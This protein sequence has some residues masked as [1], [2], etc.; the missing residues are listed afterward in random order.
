MPLDLS[1]PPPALEVA[2]YVGAATPGSLIPEFVLA[3]GRVGRGPIAGVL[4]LRVGT[5]PDTLDGIAVNIAAVSES[6]GTANP[7]ASLRDVAGGTVAFEV[8]VPAFTPR[9]TGGPFA[10][11]G[12]DLALVRKSEVVDDDGIFVAGA[13]RDTLMPGVRLAVG[14][15]LSLGKNVAVR[16]QLTDTVRA[17]STLAVADAADALG[18]AWQ[19]PLLHNDVVFSFTVLAGG[20]IP[21][22]S[23]R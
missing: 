14:A 20:A 8:G 12:L 23:P 1:H 15:N 16:A 6:M 21:A 9:F 3:G 19:A 13:T 22:R 7:L 18:D 17:G 2:G 10:Q 4:E 11:A 5:R